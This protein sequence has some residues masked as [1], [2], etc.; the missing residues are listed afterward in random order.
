MEAGIVIRNREYYRRRIKVILSGLDLKDCSILDLGAGELLL[1][2]ELKGVNYKSYLGV[3]S[4]PFQIDSQ[5]NSSD[6]FDF[7]ETVKEK[8]DALFCLGV[9]DHF[10]NSQKER[11][12]DRFERIWIRY[13]IISKANDSNLIIRLFKNRYEVPKY[14]YATQKL[15]LFKLPLSKRLYLFQSDTFFIRL[16]ATEIIYIY[17]KSEKL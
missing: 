9:L 13:L 4:I 7:I 10:D 1:R 11:L 16:I 5:F 14:D 2:E 15:Y 17:T 8:Y 3:D 6:I 12:L